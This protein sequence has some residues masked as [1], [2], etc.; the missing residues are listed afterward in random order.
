MIDLI[1]WCGKLEN[2][3]ES[4]VDVTWPREISNSRAFD[5]AGKN[6]GECC[7]RSRAFV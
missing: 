5:F 4:F 7:F 3:N 2:D 6:F 1:Q